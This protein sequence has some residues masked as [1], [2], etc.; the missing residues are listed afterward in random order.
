MSQDS[1]FP[2]GARK[3]LMAAL[4]AAFAVQGFLVYTDSTG[5]EMPPLSE[6]ALRGRDVWLERN[7]QACHQFYGFG[8]F[9]G[10]DLTNAASRLTRARLDE[11]LTV[12]SRQMPPFHLSADEI[13]WIET[14][15]REIDATGIGQA[16]APRP[17]AAA[18]DAAVRASIAG[19]EVPGDAARGAERFLSGAC[20]ACHAPLSPRRIGTYL[21]PDLSRSAGVLADEEIFEVLTNGRPELGMPPAGLAHDQQ[22]EV[23]A[24]LRWLAEQRGIL[25]EASLPDQRTGVPWWEF[26]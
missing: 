13:T 20:I 22:Q 8:G 3:G 17:D 12:G 9:L 14:Y 7:C 26:R 1:V 18:F 24:F 21:A 23:L 4:V 25:L 2:L 10:P 15:L 5:R 16:R 6:T 11:V 19:G